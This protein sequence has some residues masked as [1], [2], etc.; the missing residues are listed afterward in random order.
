[1]GVVLKVYTLMYVQGVRENVCFQPK[2]TATHPSRAYLSLCKRSSKGLNAFTT[3]V[4]C[5]SKT[6]STKCW[7]GRGGEILNIFGSFFGTPCNTYTCLYWRIRRQFPATLLMVGLV[8]WHLFNCAL[9]LL[10][11]SVV[12]SS[13]SPM[14]RNTCSK[15]SASPGLLDLFSY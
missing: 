11:P 15:G 8:W 2:S 5:H 6:K 9:S 7:R 12:T 10:R 13:H 4:Y 14:V 3:H 1:M